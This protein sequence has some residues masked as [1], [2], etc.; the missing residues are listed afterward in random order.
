MKLVLCYPAEPKHKAQ[1]AATVPHWEV[2]DAGQEGVAREILSADYYCGHAKVPVPWDEVVR[3]GRLKWIQSSAAGV[4]HCLHPAIVDSSIVVTS[5]SG[6][7]ADQVTE[8]AIG[9]ATALSRSLPTFFRAQQKK[10][11]VRRPTRDLTHATCGIVGLGGV[12][13]RLS[14]AL[15][16]FRTRIVATDF[17]PVQKPAWVEALWGPD[18]LPQLLAQSDFVFLCAPLT[19]ATRGIIRREML[20]H[21]KPGAY[22][23]NVARG[24]L[25]VEADL[26]EALDSGRLAGVAMDVAETE[27]LPPTSPLWERPDVII[28]PHVGGQSARRIDDMTNFLC[29]N[30]QRHLTHRPLRNVVDK[31]LGFPRPEAAE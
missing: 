27:P 19:A 24:Q 29:D 13:R 22:L 16:V 9:L 5:A 2:V 10:E 15:G 23:I 3:L 21:C 8:H 31:R 26:P 11:Y 6:V 18:Q 20:A 1:I 28:T 25:V 30:L 4:D 17:Y 14:K 7:L 12:G